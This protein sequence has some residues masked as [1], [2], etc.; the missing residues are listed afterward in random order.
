MTLGDE[1]VERGEVRRSPNCREG[2]FFRGAFPFGSLLLPPRFRLA[3]ACFRLGK[4]FLLPLGGVELPCFQGCL[5]RLCLIREGPATVIG[6]KRPERGNGVGALCL[7]K[8]AFFLRAT[9]RLGFR[10]AAPFLIFGLASGLGLRAFT[11]VE[12][13]E[14]PLIALIRPWRRRGTARGSGGQRYAAQAAA[15]APAIRLDVA[16]APR[17]QAPE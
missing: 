16:F 3:L 2:T 13:L 4:V 12:F 9:S 10:L 15:S 1:N 11:R 7:R 5:D 6:K 14:N 8:Q 17:R